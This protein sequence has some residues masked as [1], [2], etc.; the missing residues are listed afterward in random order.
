MSLLTVQDVHKSY[1]DLTVLKGISF[2]MEKGE[3]KVIIGPSGTGKSTLLRCVNGLTSPDEGKIWIDG[4]EVTD[5]K[6]NINTVRSNIGFVFQSFNLF[7]HLTALDNI[8][9]GPVK[10]KGM[11]RGEARLLAMEELR[12]VGLKDKAQAYP[13]ELSGGQQQRV[14]IARALAM[15]PKLMLFDEPTSALDPELIGE[16]LKVMIDLARG[17]MTM[18]VVSHEIGFSRAVADEI[19]FLDEGR[20][21]EKGPPSEILTNPRSK[22]TKEFLHKI[23]ELYGE[24]GEK[25]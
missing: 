14:S 9:I 11:K 2:Q 25:V 20:I 3:I 4:A 21:L 15:N 23:I 13:A 22:R 18:L 19:L 12:R 7:A 17:G 8:C 24:E 10:V 16:V 1:G 6:T 5:P